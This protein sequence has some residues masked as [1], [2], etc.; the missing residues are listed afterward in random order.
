MLEAV[1]RI[2]K[3]FGLGGELIL[4]LFDEF[5]ED[6]NIEEPLF[7]HIDGLAV[8]LFCD[9]FIRRGHSG[10]VAVFADFGSERRAGELTGKTLHLEMEP[11]TEEP[12]EGRVYLEDIAGFSATVDGI[13][14]CKVLDF[15]DGDNPLFRLEVSGREA[16][17]PAVEEFIAEI[18]ADRKTIVFELPAGLLD[19]YLEE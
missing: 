12:A 11:E 2:S 19:L 9:S 4:S 5:P 6:F 18:D 14:G 7:V 8:P 3:T 13:A 16:F 17:V 10:A 15:I 1:G